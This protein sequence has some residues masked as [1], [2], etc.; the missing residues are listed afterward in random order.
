LR[1]FKHLLKK[2]FILAQALLILREIV[3]QLHCPLYTSGNKF[4]PFLPLGE[5]EIEMLF[6][7]NKE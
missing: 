4:T 6:Q 5:K 2:K 7:P 3:I 1:F